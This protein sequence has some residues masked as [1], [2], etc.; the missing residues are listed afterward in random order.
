MWSSA[1]EAQ[2]YCAVEIQGQSSLRDERNRCKYRV[3]EM[4]WRE[5]N[6]DNT[7]DTNG[8]YLVQRW[9]GV[10]MSRRTGVE[11][12]GIMDMALCQ[13][14]PVVQYH[15]CHGLQCFSLDLE[16]PAGHV[17]MGSTSIGKVVVF[18]KVGAEL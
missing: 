2:I 6:G 4:A 17:V 11:W 5:H 15:P 14:V 10:E 8:N 13:V 7:Q 18:V 12:G 9:R 1:P 3:T 16:S